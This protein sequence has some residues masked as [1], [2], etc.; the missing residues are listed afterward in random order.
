MDGGRGV[1]LPIAALADFFAKGRGGD[2][3]VVVVQVQGLDVRGEVGERMEVAVAGGDEEIV[4]AQLFFDGFDAIVV[5]GDDTF[6]GVAAADDGDLPQGG[7]ATAAFA[8]HFNEQTAFG[9]DGGH[10][11]IVDGGADE[12][13][14]VAEGDLVV[15]FVGKRAGEDE[16]ELVGKGKSS[17]GEGKVGFGDGMETAGQEGQADLC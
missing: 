16:P 14:A 17:P 6:G 12:F 1:L 2:L 11:R 5:P 10:A 4:L 15:G 8:D 3:V 13:D 9:D 7:E